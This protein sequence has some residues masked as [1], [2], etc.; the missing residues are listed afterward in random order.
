MP[1]YELTFKYDKML[2]GLC[3]YEA[4]KKFTFEFSKGRPRE[5]MLYDCINIALK[6][7]ECISIHDL[8][9]GSFKKVED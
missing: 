9:E 3:K 8:V 4:E 6:E 1:K 7:D 2:R 5:Q